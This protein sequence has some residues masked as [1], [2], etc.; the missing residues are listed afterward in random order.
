MQNRRILVSLIIASIVGL[1]ALFIA[2]FIIKDESS[3]K[4]TMVVAAGENIPMGTPISGV[5]LTLVKLPGESIPAGVVRNVEELVGRV[6]K[7]EIKAGEIIF[8]RMLFSA[9]SSAGL[10]FA[11]SAGKRAMSMSVNEVSDVAGFVTPGSFVD[12]L[13]SSKD[14]TGRFSSRIILQRILVLAVAQDRLAAEDSKPRLATSVTLELTPQQA[15]MLDTARMAGSL[16]LVLRNQTE[17][18][19]IGEGTQTHT[20]SENGVEVIR[21]TSVRMESGLGR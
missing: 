5:Q 17:G 11:I 19:V 15:E 6:P 9:N 3:I 8:E 4:T 16:S 14:D 1:I 2:S 10:A 7:G 13:F 12:V 21:G 18:S 20:S